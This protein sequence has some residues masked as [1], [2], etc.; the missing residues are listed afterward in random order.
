MDEKCLVMDEKSML[1]MK[2]LVLWMK[3]L[4]L[5]MKTSFFR[6][7]DE[8]V[9]FMLETAK[10]IKTKNSSPISTLAFYVRELKQDLQEG[11]ALVKANCRVILDK[12]P[13]V[14][15]IYPVACDETVNPTNSF[16]FV[17]KYSEL[18]F[19]LQITAISAQNMR[20]YRDNHFGTEDY[21]IAICK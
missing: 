5:W 2:Q 13:D 11:G 18:R 21:N 7:L 20:K 3:Q 16:P 12:D 10:L 8:K 17:S 14:S 6:V 9:T 1:W 15:G 4:I 19:I